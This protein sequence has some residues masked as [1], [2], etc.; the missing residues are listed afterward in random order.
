[1]INGVDNWI[2]HSSSY[3]VTTSN[4]GYSITKA[5]SAFTPIKNHEKIMRI[6]IISRTAT[7][8]RWGNEH[9]SRNLL[10]MKLNMK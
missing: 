5:P 2:G 1:M 8:N 6:I 10:N 4:S 9:T 3:A 7:T